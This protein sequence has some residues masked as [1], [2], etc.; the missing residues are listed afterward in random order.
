MKKGLLAVLFVALFFNLSA[1]HRKIV[2][3][4]VGDRVLEMTEIAPSKEDKNATAV[5]F[6][7][8]G[9]WVGGD[10][11]RF[12]PQ[13][14]VLAELGAK[15]YLVDYRVKSRDKTTPDKCVEDAK[16][17]MRYVR[18][19]AKA[20]GVNPKKV[21]AAGGSAGG[22]MAAALAFVKGMD[23]SSDNLD[24]SCVPDAMLLYNPVVDNSPGAYY[25][26]TLEVVGW[27]NISPLHNI[28]KYSPPAIFFVG[29]KDKHISVKSSE[30]FRDKINA[31]GTHE[32]E[33]HVYP[34]CKHGFYNFGKPDYQ[35]VMDK[36]IDFLKRKSFL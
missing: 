25:K 19:N 1:Q 23:A 33:L 36:T 15:C 9:A 7:Y 13:A 30:E 26:E 17:A 12:L 28:G 21:V 35:D 10:L 32:C 4:Q 22:H 20:L 3:K 6:F 27:K 34:E 31:T 24:I 5:L 11:D 16:S 2:Y 8:P 18:E 29:D 14:K